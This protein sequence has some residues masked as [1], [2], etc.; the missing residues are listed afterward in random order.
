MP[1]TKRRTSGTRELVTP[2][3]DRRFVKRS[4]TG[5]FKESDDAGKSLAADRRTKAKTKVRSGHGD[6]GDR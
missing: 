3:G 4:A 6:R 5:E 2:R 1:T